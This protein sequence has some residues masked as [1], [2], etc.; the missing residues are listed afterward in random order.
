MKLVLLVLVASVLVG[1][2]AGGRLTGL[3]G[4]RIR[5]APLAIV[6]L[7]LQMLLPPGN[8]PFVLLMISFGMLLAFVI[9]NRGIPGFTLIL[10]GLLMNLIVIAVN[11]GMPVPRYALEASGQSETLSELVEHGGAKHHLATEDDRLMFLA[12]VIPLRPPVAQAVSVGDIVAYVGVGVV[13]VVAM[14][15]DRRGAP[16]RFAEVEGASDA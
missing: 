4:L 15:R 1:L 9:V 13:I 12:D 2:V 5:W 8:W 16:A 3:S 11:S 14:R 6:G 7:G 10:A